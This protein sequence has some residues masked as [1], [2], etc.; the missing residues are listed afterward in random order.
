MQDRCTEGAFAEE[1]HA[2][3]EGLLL[4]LKSLYVL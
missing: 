3:S 4:S 2:V 1:V